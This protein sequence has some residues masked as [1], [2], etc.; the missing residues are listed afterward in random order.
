MSNVDLGI[1]GQPIEGTAPAVAIPET[2]SQSASR[3]QPT[4]EQGNMSIE[5]YEVEFTRLSRFVPHM[6]ATEKEKTD[7]FIL[8][9][10]TLES[11]RG[12]NGQKRPNIY[13]YDI[14]SGMDWLYVHHASIDCYKKEIVS[15]PDGKELPVSGYEAGK[16][17]YDL[18]CHRGEL[19][20]FVKKKDGTLRLYTDYRELNKVTIKNKYPLPRIDDLF[21][22]L[23]GAAVFSK[24][25]LRSGY[26]QIRV[27]E[28]DVPKTVFRTR[29]GHYELVVMSFGLTNAPAVFMELMNRTNDE[30]AEHLRKVLLVLRKQRLY[31]KFSKCQFWLQKLEQGNMSIEKYE[32][33]FTR[34][35]R[36]VPHMD[37]TEKEKI[38]LFILGL[39]TEM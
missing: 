2:T 11:N 5:K 39:R 38:D 32:V 36:F 19:V 29:Y 20:L 18:V 21:D 25:D 1:E 13:D 33:E 8:D 6:D 3:D 31:A 27:K 22:Q 7:L 14:I 30:H 26:H 28:D 17:S 9:A 10:A 16:G 34:L 23:Q 4:L 15:P 12:F 35:S 37:A 24:I